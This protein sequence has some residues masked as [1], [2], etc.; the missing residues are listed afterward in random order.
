M[1]VTDSSLYTHTNN[2]KY[3][4]GLTYADLDENIHY[5]TTRIP[6]YENDRHIV[7]YRFFIPDDGITLGRK[8]PTSVHTPDV[9]RMVAV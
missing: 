5:A 4:V 9:V 3:I 8:E 2:F 7:A 6:I 1:D